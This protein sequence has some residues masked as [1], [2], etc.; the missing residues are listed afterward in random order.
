VITGPSG[1]GKSTI[2]RRAREL[3]EAEYSVSAT[4][5]EPRDGERD[6]ED[7]FF[8]DDETFKR[9]V[10]DGQM[11]E[12]AEVFGC[13]YGTPAAQV[14][15]AVARGEK[16]ILDVDVQGG[17]QVADKIPNA[18]FIL[19]VPPDMETLRERLTHRGSETTEQLER[20]LGKAQS[21]LSIARESGVYKIEI[22]NDD[23]DDAIQRVVDEI[24]QE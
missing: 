23:L 22:I 16:I 1:V 2:V 17:I 11:L 5:R 12:W 20:R 14:R 19:I 10:D 21:E 8:I 15:D 13:S 9:M 7:Y 3:C 6:K 24:N 18:K 4:T